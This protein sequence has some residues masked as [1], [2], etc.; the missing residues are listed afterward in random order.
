MEPIIFKCEARLWEMMAVGEK[1]FDMRRWDLGDERILRLAKLRWV[2]EPS[3][4]EPDE[5]FVAFQ[6]KAT[7]EVLT[8]RFRGIKFADWAPGW[9]FLILGG[10]VAYHE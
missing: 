6:N 7:G 3:V 5:P 1:P 9:V 10:S 4:W 8:F 2:G